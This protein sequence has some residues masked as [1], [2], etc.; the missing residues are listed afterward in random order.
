M[1]RFVER[2]RRVVLRGALDFNSLTK[3]PKTRGFHSFRLDL[4][5]GAAAIFIRLRQHSPHGAAA[6]SL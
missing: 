2:L 5:P 3:L 4:I 6:L 1:K